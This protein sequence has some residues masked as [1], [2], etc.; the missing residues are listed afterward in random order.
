MISIL[1]D[2]S[3]TEESRQKGN[4][5]EGRYRLYGIFLGMR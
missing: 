5:A 1:P 2:V 4:N 3:G